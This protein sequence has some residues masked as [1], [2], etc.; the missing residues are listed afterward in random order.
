VSKLAPYWKAAAGFVAPGLAL[1]VADVASDQAL[2]THNEWLAIGLAC[3][4]G[5]TGVY[6]APKNAVKR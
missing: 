1:F 3:I 6:V 4:A 5:A 2:P